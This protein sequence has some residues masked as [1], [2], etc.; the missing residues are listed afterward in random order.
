MVCLGKS[1]PF[2]FFKGC[3]PQILLGPLLNTLS[4]MYRLHFFLLPFF[5]ENLTNYQTYKFL[6]TFKN[7]D[8]FLKTYKFSPAKNVGIF[9]M[10]FKSVAGIEKNLNPLVS[11]V[12]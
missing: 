12:H 5:K 2:N 8:K 7:F 3:L 1:Y 4:Q 11:G 9:R 6:L 10:K